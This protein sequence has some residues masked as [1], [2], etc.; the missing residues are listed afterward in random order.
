MN[1]INFLGHSGL[2]VSGTPSTLPSE[3]RAACL[4]PA[5]LKIA[6]R[7]REHICPMRATNALRRVVGR[8]SGGRFE[9]IRTTFADRGMVTATNLSD[10]HR[11]RPCRHRHLGS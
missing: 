5:R 7:L 3:Y 2:L 8:H 9:K 1:S 4:H 11:H 6:V 10:S